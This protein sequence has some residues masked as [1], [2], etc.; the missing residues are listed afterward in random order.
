MQCARLR[1]V[2]FP[3]FSFLRATSIMSKTALRAVSR[4]L[5]LSRSI[6]SVAAASAFILCHR[7]LTALRA[8]LLR[9]SGVKFRA[10]AS[11][12]FLPAVT[13]VSS[14]VISASASACR[15]LQQPLDGADIPQQ[16]AVGFARTEVGARADTGVEAK[17]WDHLIPVG[18]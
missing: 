9:C 13:K 4:Y 3:S 18:T 2:S 16:V 10:R 12:P 14:I 6:F 5:F 8:A 1:A 17:A 11:P 7:A 15:F